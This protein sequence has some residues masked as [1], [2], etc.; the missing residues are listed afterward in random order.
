MKIAVLGSGVIG[1]TTAWYLS[2]AG[3]EVV[4]IDRQAKSGQETSFANAGQI[5]YGYSSPWAAPGIPQKAIRW[6]FEQH[7][8]LKVQPKVDITMLNWAMQMLS[9]CQLTRYEVNKSRMLKVANHSRECLQQLNQELGLEYQGRQRGTLQVFRSEKQ[10][11][12]VEKDIRLLQQ[13]NTRFKLLNPQQCLEQEPGLAPV[14]D[15]LKGGLYLPDDETGDCQLFCQQLT[16]KAQQQGVEFKFDHTI[17]GLGRSSGKITS[18]I[19]D[20]ETLHADAFVVAMGSYSVPLLASIGIT[21]P[22]YPVK[23]Y[24]LTAPIIDPTLAPT[25]TVMD[26][27]YKVALTRFDDRI[28]VAGTAELAGFDPTI[29]EKRKST[30]SMVA[31]DLFPHSAN[32]EHAEYWTGF[33]PMTP[34]G[35]PIIGKT[36]YQ[37]LFTN[38]G[39]GTLGWTMACGSAQLLSQVITQS[40]KAYPMATQPLIDGLDLSRYQ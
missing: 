40:T 35:T 24:S 34:D 18:V 30:I 19:T 11:D 29:P 14:I 12:A 28:R 2:K 39:H 7:A 25:S 20:K 1:V 17:Q 31:K 6:L 32:F 15:K 33:R 22:V 36:G 8:P 37:N 10:L 23:G 16:Q 26:E 3:H 21:I 38:T 27:T 4:V 9:N 5:S 13:A